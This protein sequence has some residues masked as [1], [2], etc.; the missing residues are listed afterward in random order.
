MPPFPG[1]ARGGLTASLALKPGS[2]SRF[3]QHAAPR[4]GDLPAHGCLCCA[5]DEQEELGRRVSNISAALQSCRL[6]AAAHTRS[7]RG[8][9]CV[10][11]HENCKGKNG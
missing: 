11:V 7:L 5:V 10:F 6:P 1:A 2:F 4:K 3:L 9:R 8:E